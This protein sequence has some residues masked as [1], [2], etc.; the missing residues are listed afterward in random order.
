[1][2]L[3]VFFAYKDFLETYGFA[4]IL[5]ILGD[6]LKFQETLMCKKP[7]VHNFKLRFI[8]DYLRNLKCWEKTKDEVVVST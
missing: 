7:F 2:V 6:L 4:Q 5:R 3:N 8:E 1:M